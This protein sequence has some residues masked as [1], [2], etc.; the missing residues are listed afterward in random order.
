MNIPIFQ[1]DAFTNKHFSGNPAAICPMDAWLDE[2]IMQKIALENNLSETA[3]F[4]KEQD[5]YHIRW[6]TPAVEVDLCGHATLAAAHVLFQHLQHPADIVEFIS[7]SG[8]LSV[9]K[10]GEEYVLDFPTDKIHSLDHAEDIIKFIGAV[11][12]DAWKGR[13]DYLLVY[14]NQEDIEHIQPDFKSLAGAT[15]RGVIVTAP[16]NE[17]DFVSRFFAPQ[18]GIDEDPV[19]G[20]AHTTLTP[21]WSKRLNKKTMHARQLSERGGTLTCTH[22]GDRVKISGKA[23]T[24]LKGHI[25]LNET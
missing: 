18:A 8:T 11:P 17:V 20:S 4:V 21:Y 9:K 10:H 15:E 13:E 5:K 3:F 22:Q 16:G 2:Q 25:F 1:I 7:K 6:F 19:T 14:S 24:F 23:V 12:V